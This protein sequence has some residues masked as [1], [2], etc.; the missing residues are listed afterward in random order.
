MKIAIDAKV[1]DNRLD[2]I[3]VRLVNQLVDD[4]TR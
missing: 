3:W 2:E 4:L 1:P